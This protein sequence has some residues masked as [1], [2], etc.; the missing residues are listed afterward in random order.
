MHLK[1]GRFGKLKGFFQNRGK[2]FWVPI[3]TLA[4]LAIGSGVLLM[5]QASS[6]VYIESTTSYRGS[7]YAPYEWV[8]GEKVYSYPIYYG[9][10]SNSPQYPHVTYWYKVT[11]QTTGASYDAMCLQARLTSPN[12]YGAVAVNTADIKKIMIATVPSY[13][14]GAPVN[15]YNAFASYLSSQGT[16]WDALTGQI[17]NLRT[18][19]TDQLKYSTNHTYANVVNGDEKACYANYY[20]GSTC[21]NMWSDSCQAILNSSDRGLSQSKVRTKDAVFA[22][23]HILASDIYDTDGY[24]RVSDSAA[25]LNTIKGYINA[26]FNQPAYAN[27]PDAYDAYASWVNADEQTVGWL[28]YK[29]IPDPTRIRICKK[30]TS[31]TMLPGATFR[32]GLSSSPY[33][34][35]GSDGC[36]AWIEV[37][38]T[39]IYYTETTAPSGYSLYSSEQTCHVTTENADNTCWAHDNEK[40]PTA[41]IKIKKVNTENSGVSYA[42][43]TVVGTKFCVYDS[44]HSCSSPNTTITIGSDGTGTTDVALPAGTYVISEK[45]ATTGYSLNSASVTVELNS[46]NTAATPPTVD[47]TTS[48]TA[49]SSGSSPCWFKNA[50][51]KGKISLTKTGYEMTTSGSAGTRNL[52]GIYFTAVNQ[53][54]NNITYSIGPT[55][56]NGSVTSPEM[57]YGTYTVTE[58]RGNSNNAYNLLSFT[59]TVNS[60]ST[61]AISADQT[62]DTIP[63]TP[64]L[65]TIARNSNSTYESPDKEIEI[66]DSASITDRI[67][68][69]GLQSGAQYKLEGEVYELSSSTSIG[70]TGTSTF[71]ADSSGTCGNLDM[72]LSA[73]GSYNY[74]DKTLSIKQI[75]YKNNGTSSNPD[76]VRIFIH[77]ANLAD[78]NEQV[79]VKTIEITTTANSERTINNKELAAGKVKILDTYEIIGMSNG[80]TYTL[81]GTVKDASGNTVATATD[82][83]NMTL[84]T[85]AAYTNVMTFEFDSTPYVGQTL[86]VHQTLKSSSG[87]ALATHTGTA[88]NGETVTVLTPTLITNATSATD[89]T[90]E[91]YVGT[92]DV[93]DTVTYTGLAAGSTYTIKGELWKLKADGTK[94]FK[95]ADATDSFTASSEDDTTTGRTLTFSNIDAIT[96][97]AVDNKLTLPCK[98]VVFEYIYYG[99]NSSYF[100]KHEDTTDTQQI[101]SVK[102]PTISTV[103][104]DSQNNSKKFSIGS[105]SVLDKVTYGNLVPNQQYIVRGKLVYADSGTVVQDKDGA[106]MTAIESFTAAANSATITVDSFKKFDSTFDYD[107]SLGENQKK[108]VVY[109]TLYYGD[110]ELIAHEDLTDTDQTLQI[111]V[112]SL[113]TDARYKNRYDENAS[114]LLGVGDVTMIDYVDYTGLVEGEWYTIVGYIVDP[115]T[116]DIVKINDEYVENSKTFKAGEKG[117]GTVTLE[118]N[119]NTITLQGR[120]FVVHEELYRSPRDNQNDDRLLAEHKEALDEG[121]QTIGVKIAKLE[122]TA[123]DKADGD[124]VLAHEDGQTIHDVVEY[125]GLLMDEEYTLYGYLWDKT[126]NQPLLKDGKRIEAFASFTTPTRRDSGTIE[127]EFQVDAYDLPGVEIVVYEYLFQGDQDSVPFGDDEYPDTEQVVTKHADPDSVS[128]TV[129]VSM[130]VGT[131]AV[132]AYDNDHTAGVGPVEIIDN[133]AYEGVTRGKKYKAKG[134][135]VYKTADGTHAAGDKAQGVEVTY[136]TTCED[137]SEDEETEDEEEA[138]TE[139]PECTTTRTVSYYDIEGVSEIFTI[140]ATDDTSG[141][142]PIHLTFDSRELIGQDLVVYEELYLVNDDGTEE[143]VAEHKDLEDEGQTVTIATPEIH[144]T[145]TDLADG[146]K[147]LLHDADVI[148]LDKVEYTGLVKGATYTLKG[149]LVDKASGNRISGGVTEVIWTFTPTHDSGTEELEFAINTTGLTGKELVV[150]E[151]LYIEESTDDE[152]KIAE[153]QDLNDAAQTVNVKVDRPNTGLFTHGAEGALQTGVVIILISGLAVGTGVFIIRRKRQK[154]HGTVSFE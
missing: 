59:A 109:Q 11:D 64:A 29:G 107:F 43:L 94:D 128:Q 99:S 76:W 86:Y 26:F 150:F 41:Y 58:V 6:T 108:Y 83:I 62:N 120:K 65:T 78:T 139:E 127:M 54:D 98:F 125:D 129:R 3:F 47:Y 132:D 18:R 117:I 92:V 9:V 60:T 52:A 149:Q 123:T 17:T 152:D 105:V 24:Y 71:T 2:R 33:Y 27:V 14:D 25:T 135:L 61:A 133:L 141:S 96:N 101:V 82:T 21:N 20:F 16:S 15:Y 55:D 10:N 137:E 153:H 121:D 67:T 46:S 119:V 48:S 36:T 144:T 136:T 50:P 79:K 112:P 5:A 44:S 100:Q 90:K 93:K 34:T 77:N 23:G 74:M 66:S 111:G 102:N 91:L 70:S 151:T 31:G 49:C 73:F 147:E 103:A 30:S 7:E 45:T 85:G 126:N 114:K 57:V 124:G 19:D 51:I 116:G 89:G 106:D 38:A 13:S 134:W 81:E 154:L 143:L 72:V 95:V 138:V 84:A 146:D 4:V 12:G 1:S 104:T 140:G 39:D 87:T 115:E 118:I 53:A 69:S 75:L 35:T 145:A 130:R 110:I 68:C 63:D 80:Q 122:T 8:N 148:I 131:E 42:G 32:L 56:A 40:I 28:Q 37:D 142:I 88:D 113:H 22:V 97:C